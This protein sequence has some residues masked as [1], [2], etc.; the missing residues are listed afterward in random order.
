[1]T[2]SKSHN[3]EAA[4]TDYYPDAGEPP[5]AH[6]LAHALAARLAARRGA[7]V[8]LVGIGNGRNVAP[9]LSAG[10]RVYAVDEDAA[11][12]AGAAQTFASNDHVRIAHACYNEP[13]ARTERFAGALSTHALL[14]GTPP[15]VASAVQA[16][17]ARLTTGGLFF[18]TLG[19]VRDQRF[20]RGTRVA[21]GAFA[22]TEGREAGVVHSFFDEAGVRALFGGFELEE[23]REDSAATTVGTWAHERDQS[24]DIVHW[25]VRARRAC[26]Q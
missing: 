17:R 4:A 23:V 18:V 3:A 25:F 11:R 14:H 15:T 5:V 21:D 9:F 6:P 1:M 20:G 7:W 22:L 8:C 19:S 2:H 16:V 10:L 12:V 24:R 13:I 26:D